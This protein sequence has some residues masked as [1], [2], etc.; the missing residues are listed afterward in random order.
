MSGN[1]V[2]ITDFTDFTLQTNALQY[3]KP[4]ERNH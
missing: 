2:K 1:N 4:L 3:V